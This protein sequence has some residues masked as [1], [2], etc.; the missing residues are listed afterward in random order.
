MRHAPGDRQLSRIAG[1][2]RCF[3]GRAYWVVDGTSRVSGEIQVCNNAGWA[4]ALVDV[5]GDQAGFGDWPTEVRAATAENSTGVA[6]SIAAQSCS[7]GLA[8]WCVS[9]EGNAAAVTAATAHPTATAIAPCHPDFDARSQLLWTDS[10]LAQGIVGEWGCLER[11]P[12]RAERVD[13]WRSG[14]VIPPRVAG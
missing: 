8:A 7:D 4:V 6:G 1:A 5:C 10:V 3:R 12:A 13:S 9:Y 2:G 11:C 14:A